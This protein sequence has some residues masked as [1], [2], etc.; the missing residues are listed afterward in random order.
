MRV[1]YS[2]HRPYVQYRR[3]YVQ[4]ITLAFC[5]QVNG[6]LQV[7]AQ[8]RS[9]KDWAEDVRSGTRRVICDMTCDL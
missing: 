9:T 8:R 5:P 7:G 2:G 4:Y 3:P 1:A 6:P